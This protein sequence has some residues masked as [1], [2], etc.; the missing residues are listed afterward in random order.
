MFPV[1]PPGLGFLV[2]ENRSLDLWQCAFATIGACRGGRLDVRNL[3]H[4][5]ILLMRD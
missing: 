2:R 5:L 3:Q 1:K 4:H